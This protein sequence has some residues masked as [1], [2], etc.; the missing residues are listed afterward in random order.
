MSDYNSSDLTSILVYI[1]NKF[2]PDVFVRQGQ[3]PALVSDLAPGLKNDR[4]MLERMTRLGILKGFVSVAAEE[5]EMQKRLIARS[6]IQLTNSEYIR[7]VIAAAYLRILVTVFGWNIEVEIPRESAFE[8]MKF[9]SERFMRESRDQDFLLGKK[10]SDAEE[11]DEARL[12]FGKAYESGNV[13]AGVHLGEIYYLG[14]GGEC[15]YDKAMPLFVDGM[16]RGYPLGAVWLAEAYRTGR[17]VP[18][19]KD[20]SKETFYLSVDALEAMC[21]SGS[22]NAQYVYGF[23]LLYGTF[24]AADNQKA[25]YWLEKAM[26]AGHVN[27]GLEVAKTYLHGWGHA[28][29]EQKGV[30]ILEQYAGTTSRNVHYEHGKVFCYGRSKGQNHKKDLKH[31]LAAAKRGHARS[32]DFLGDIYYFGLSVEKNY[33]EAQKWYELASQKNIKNSLR[34]LGLI[35]YSGLG[36]QKDYDKAFTYFKKA[37]DLGDS[38]AQFK[39]VYFYV[40]GLGDGKYTDYKSGFYY[41]EKSAEQGNPQA[42]RELW[43]L[44]ES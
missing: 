1:K 16:N 26:R 31:L 30:E 38:S 17:G 42:Q 32:Q 23:N 40:Y 3:V 6:M 13:L 11:F 41:L 24:S 20:K 19:D 14:H 36:V 34:N 39:L 22:A 44:K 2:G 28:K 27:A 25:C 15:D 9:D 29:D 21:A 10:A 7:P 37:A 5:K 43:R 35:Y 33:S 8:K 4:V 18:K 12:L